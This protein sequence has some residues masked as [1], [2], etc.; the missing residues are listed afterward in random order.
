MP[1]IDPRVLA[2]AGAD[3]LRRGDARLARESFETIA[4]AGIADAS[5]WLG[6]AF[7]CRGLGDKA[8]ALAAVDRSLS[9]EPRNLRA[10]ILKADHLAESG[11]ARGASSFYQFAL[12]AAPP[13]GQLPA[14]LRSELGRA[15]AMCARYAGQFE[16]FL[17]ERLVGNGLVEGR[18][19]ARFRHS[20]DIMLGKRKIHF[21]EPHTYYFPE[22]PQ[23]QFYD[24]SDFSWV[25]GVE[26]ATA[27]IRAELLEVMKEDSAFTPYVQGDPR[28]P[29][30]EQSG[31]Q[32]NPDWSAFYLWKNGEPVT[33][34][35][36]RCPKTLA[37]M[38][39]VPLARVANR[40]PSVLFSLLRPGARIPP[41]TG[42]VNTRLICHLPLIVPPNCGL[43]VGNETR[44]PVEGRVWMFD[45]TMEHEAWNGSDRTRVILLFEIWRPELTEAER[46]L[47]TSMFEAIDTYSGQKPA[48]EI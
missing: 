11:D 8:A 48:W 24:S 5:S 2:Q 46:R 32:D 35:A 22:L 41:H 38:A 18:T 45:D 36:A 12:Q 44:T 21:Q 34:N 4:K 13:A 37:A 9:L 43:R 16:D 39:G 30:K 14:D 31:M 1:P 29:R 7:A 28:R 19:A 20:L 15:Q 26:A 40:S 25:S 6:L 17:R 42:L 27:D 10:L 23:I 33:A 3:A 47:V